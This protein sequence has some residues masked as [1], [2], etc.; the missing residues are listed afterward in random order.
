MIFKMDVARSNLYSSTVKIDDRTVEISEG[1]EGFSRY[2]AELDEGY[3]HI[4]LRISTIVQKKGDGLFT[5][6]LTLAIFNADSI[7]ADSKT[8]KYS[9]DV[10]IGEKKDT[11]YLDHNGNSVGSLTN[12]EIL[13]T[14]KDDEYDYKDFKEL[15]RFSAFFLAPVII[16]AAVM[17]ILYSVAFPT[18]LGEKYMLLKQIAV[19]IA[20]GALV[21]LGVSLI[22]KVIKLSKMLK[23]HK[24]R[25]EKYDKL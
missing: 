17:C 24:N 12:A 9:Y 2:I 4:E 23:K 13:H 6:G 21:V 18:L 25:E 15:I 20:G 22:V 19:G 1:N 7:L 16:F 14:S 8:V 3:H 11:L 10:K 5:S